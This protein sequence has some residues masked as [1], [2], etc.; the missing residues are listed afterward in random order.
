VFDQLKSQE[1]LHGN[2][3]TAIPPSPKIAKV[4]DEIVRIR[5]T[6]EQMDARLS[7]AGAGGELQRC[8]AR[9]CPS[10]G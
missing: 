2:C 6:E 7:V 9:R 10:R 8:P 1:I 4:A 5:K 3:A